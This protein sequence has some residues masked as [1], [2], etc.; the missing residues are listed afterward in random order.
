M[1]PR[2]TRLRRQRFAMYA[3][4]IMKRT[5][6]Y[7]DES[8]DERLAKRAAAAGTTK[9]NLIREA[10]DVFLAGHDDD[11]VQLQS[12]RAAV[13]A[14]AGTASRLPAGRRYAEDL[15]KA[16]AERSAELDRRRRR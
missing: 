16:D 3:T 10:L 9:S 1:V 14:A 13:R 2:Y 7:L 5:Q 4:Y 8:Q 11:R 12:F 6:I 15:R